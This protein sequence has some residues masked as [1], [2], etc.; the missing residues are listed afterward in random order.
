MAD[1]VI[2]EASVFTWSRER[3]LVPVYDKLLT[4]APESPCLDLIQ[5]LGETKKGVMADCNELLA[6][7]G[8]DIPGKFD[9]LSVPDDISEIIPFLYDRE[10]ELLDAGYLRLDPHVEETT[11]RGI[12]VRVSRRKSNQLALLKRIAERCN[13]ILVIAPGKDHDHYPPPHPGYPP[14]HP[15]PPGHH[16]GPPPHPGQPPGTVTEY[17]VQPGDTMF[18]IAKRHGIPLETLIAA[19]PQIR[20]PDLIFPGDVI[21][22]PRR[23]HPVPPPHGGMPG[24]RRYIVVK[25]DTI[26]IIAG[27]FGIS[28]SELVAF[29][30]GLT[31]ESS[32]SP[33][34]VIL[35]PAG[36]AL[37]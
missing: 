1:Q 15:G 23:G 2:M 26:I 4:L 34:Q 24:G 37:G 19:N 25:G 21:R 3:E 35:I 6:A 5:E 7:L 31:L 32:L 18:L 22:I 13:I 29:N 12:M 20:N 9:D 16:P 11:A 10:N 17:V 28:P 33:G 27:R 14:H 36:G 8:V 30:P